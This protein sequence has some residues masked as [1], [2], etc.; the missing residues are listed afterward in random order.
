M[1][2]AYYEVIKNP[3]DLQTIRQR[4]LAH[5]YETREGFLNDIRQL[6]ENSRQFNGEYDQITRDAQ[7]I[8]AACFQKFAAVNIIRKILNISLV[9]FS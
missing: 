5:T 6:V 8:F 7:T 1:Y 3:I 2:P 4:V 9:L